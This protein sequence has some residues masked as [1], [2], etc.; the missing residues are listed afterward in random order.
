MTRLP[1]TDGRAD[2]GGERVLDRAL[3]AWRRDCVGARPRAALA[4]RV[5]ARAAAAEDEWTRFRR[6]ARAYAAAA[7]AV[8]VAGGAGI[9]IARS[10]A[11]APAEAPAVVADLEAARLQWAG[12]DFDLAVGGASA[13]ARA[14]GDR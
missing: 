1:T 13:D 11:P 6:R 3:D 2:D 10:A 4:E 8:V 9:A 14:S 12:I 5:L 7:A